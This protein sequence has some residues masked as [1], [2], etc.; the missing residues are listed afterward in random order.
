MAKQ[1]Q[2]RVAGK[3]GQHV[4]HAVHPK[5]RE[6]DERHEVSVGK[7]KRSHKKGEKSHAR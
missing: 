3:S 7:G 4:E 6:H 1:K 2:H 5:R